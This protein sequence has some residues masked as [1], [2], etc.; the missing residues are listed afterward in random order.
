MTWHVLGGG[1]LGGLWAARLSRAGLPVRLIL[2]SRARLDD[3][4]QAGGLT[5]TEQGQTQ[6]HPI[7]AELADT[8]APIE[9]LLL[10][11]KAYDA[12]PAIRSLAARIQPGAQVLLLQNGLGSQQSVA[13]HLPRARCIVLSSTEGAFR[14][15]DF[16]IV[17]AGKGQNWLGDDQ[18]PPTW[19]GELERAG[20]PHEW[21]SDIQTRLWRKLA[22]NCA[23]NPLTVLHD[24]RNG[25]LLS[26]QD[27]VRALCE[28]LA[29]LLQHAGQADAA[30]GLSE[31]V[32]QVIEGTAA[33]LSSMQQDVRAGRRTELDYLL[34]HACRRADE[35]ALP[36]PRLSAL[37]ARIQAWLQAHGLP[38]H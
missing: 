6:R 24:C 10:A 16:H 34:G 26:H 23:I 2:R 35:L 19:L 15:A 28:E 4:Q 1:S 33:N 8:A 5:L 30:E 11:C 3:Y 21:T 37:L 32:L 7:I 17:F 31:Q 29:L 38:C 18:P 9:R 27:E 25:G 13:E 22:I 14:L 12:L 20:I 36:V